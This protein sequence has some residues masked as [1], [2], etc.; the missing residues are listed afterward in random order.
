MSDLLT[1][2]AVSLTDPWATL[3]VAG[4]KTL[5]TRRGPLLSGFSGPL[6]ICRTK[7]PPADYDLSR[8]GVTLP[9]KPYTEDDRGMGI[10]VVFVKH[11][12]RAEG[13]FWRPVWFDSARLA[14]IRRRACFD[15]IEGRYLSDLSAAAWFPRP[16]PAKG[17]QTRF[18]VEVP[19]AYLPEW[20]RVSQ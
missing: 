3:V 9:E 14:A 12:E 2:P 20:A 4:I 19:A 17:Q 15:D 13:I 8:F 5:E 18:K 10:G 1:L 11:T 16:I 7:A 6:V